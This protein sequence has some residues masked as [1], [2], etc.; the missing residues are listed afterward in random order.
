MTNSFLKRMNQHTIGKAGR[1]SEKRLAKQLNGR[2]QPASGAVEGLK[3]D[4]V[5]A[6]VLMEA[7]S[8]TGNSISIK[9]E[10]LSKIAYEARNETKIPAVAI[11][12]VTPEGKP[13]ISGDWV[14]VPRHVWEEHLNHEDQ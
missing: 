14:M 12:F 4:I 9:H 11:S 10:W 2:A 13:V 1:A 5:F 7:K 8:T 3:G 6:K